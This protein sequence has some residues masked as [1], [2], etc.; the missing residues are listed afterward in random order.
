MVMRINTR[1]RGIAI[2]PRIMEQVH[3]RLHTRTVDR[4]GGTFPICCGPLRSVRRICAQQLHDIMARGEGGPSRVTANWG[5]WALFSLPLDRTI[6][7]VV[8]WGLI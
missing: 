8:G 1:S 5:G 2:R 6:E 3:T 4:C 7:A